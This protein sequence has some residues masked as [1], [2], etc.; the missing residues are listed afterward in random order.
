MKLDQYFPEEELSTARNLIFEFYDRLLLDDNLSD[1]DAVLLALYMC[2][3]KNKRAEVNYNEVKDLF[4]SMG[5]KEDNFRKR[6]HDAKNANLVNE[7]E[8]RGTKFLSLTIK[9][10]KRVKDLLG[11]EIGARTWLIESGKVYSGKKLFQQVVLSNIG[12]QLKIC[13]PYCGVRLLDVLSE[14]K[15]KCKVFLLT[16][17]IVEKRKFQR[18]LKDFMKE[19]PE[20]EI[21]VRIFNERKLHDRYIISDGNCWAIGSSLKDLGNKDTIITKLGNEVKYALEEIFEKRWKNATPLS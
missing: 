5:R 4:A 19:H 18:E 3:N 10:L 8:E 20:I 13:D 21:E 14:I 1:L 2:C 6:L 17:T 12:L 15:G 11:Y 16:Q 7:R 9:G